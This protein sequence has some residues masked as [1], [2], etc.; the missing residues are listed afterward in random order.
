MIR[1][2]LKKKSVPLPLPVHWMSALLR[3][4]FHSRNPKLDLKTQGEIF[5]VMAFDT[6][7]DPSETFRLLG[8]DPSQYSIDRT[9]QPVINESLS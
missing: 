7:Y 5:G 2:A 4:T 9:L 8:I 1:L 6:V 3:H